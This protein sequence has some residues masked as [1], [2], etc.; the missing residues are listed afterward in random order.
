[1]ERESFGGRQTQLVF[2]EEQAASRNQGQLKRKFA[3]IRSEFS[4]RF[5][6]PVLMGDQ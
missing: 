4:D 1:M 5:D 2:P 6:V 3:T